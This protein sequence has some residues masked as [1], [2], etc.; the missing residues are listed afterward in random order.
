MD[1]T[2]SH[3]GNTIKIQV[4]SSGLVVVTDTG[5]WHE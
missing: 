2:M 5:L 1:K 4:V 3:N